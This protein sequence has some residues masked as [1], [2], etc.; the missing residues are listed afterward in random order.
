MGAVDDRV[1]RGKLGRWAGGDEQ[2]SNKMD[3][4][5]WQ[6]LLFAFLRGGL[7]FGAQSGVQELEEMLCTAYPMDYR[8]SK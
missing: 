3:E 4:Q 2:F 7:F 8:F 6:N 5:R 1:L